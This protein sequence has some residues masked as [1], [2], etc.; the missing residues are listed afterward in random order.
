MAVTSTVAPVSARMAGQRPVMPTM[1]VTRNTAL[2]PERDGD[3]LADV[4]HGVRRDK[5]DHRGDIADP[6]V[7]HR[8]IRRLQGHVGAAAHGDADVGGRE[9]R[10]VVDAVADLGDDLAPSV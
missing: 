6:A 1:V 7:Q 2:R 9:R 5:I 10:S 3:V 4:A 8:R